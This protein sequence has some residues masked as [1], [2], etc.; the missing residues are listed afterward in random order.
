MNFDEAHGKSDDSR[1]RRQQARVK[2]PGP[3]T[4]EG[5]EWNVCLE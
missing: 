1:V 2:V 5:K 3:G 4:G